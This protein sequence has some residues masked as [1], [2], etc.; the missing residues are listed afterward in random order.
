MFEK[1]KVSDKVA[2]I[3]QKS[4]S[5]D[6]PVLLTTFNEASLVFYLD[7]HPLVDLT[8]EREKAAASLIAAQATQPGTPP[9]PPRP[10]Q[11]GA[12]ALSLWA[13]KR[14]PGILVIPA[15]DF[16]LYSEHARIP[17]MHTLGEVSGFNYS[18]GK[19][20]QLFVLRRQE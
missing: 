9:K 7:K 12:E 13:Q 17:A 11:I 14:G 18:K 6:V 3:I 15:S 1:L 19:W 20:V 10:I 8:A 5:P 2:A 4:S 16:A